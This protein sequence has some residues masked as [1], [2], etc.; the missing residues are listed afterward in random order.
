MR[1][2]LI[3]LVVLFATLG[4]L[5]GALNS[6]S[7][8]YDFYFTEWHLPKGATLLFALLIGWLLGGLLVY[9][10]LVLGLR[11]RVRAQTRELKRLS[12]SMTQNESSRP[13]IMT[14]PRD[15]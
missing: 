14:P 6:E 12:Q 8:G 2:A 5:F 11:R 9:G 3:L 10:G 4:A 13:L 7:V 15:A 1:F